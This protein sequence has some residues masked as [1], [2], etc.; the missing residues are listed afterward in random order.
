MNEVLI[1]NLSRTLKSPVLARCCETFFCRLRGLMFRKRIDF[2][3]GLLLVQ[4]K[5]GRVNTSIH[6]MFV[7]MDLT[8]IWLDKEWAVVDKKLARSWH[9][10][11]TPAQ[12]AKYVLE[13][14]PD[15]YAEFEI[16]D[17]LSVEQT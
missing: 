4:K 13:L 10:N 6:M 15:R 11:Y 3:Q 14:A 17:H 16:G 8:I 12:P 7:F 1:H 5:T 9:L 2:N